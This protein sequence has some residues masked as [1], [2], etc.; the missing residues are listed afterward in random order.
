[1]NHT[2][3]GYILLIE[4]DPWLAE[5]Y[6]SLLAD[7]PKV[8]IVNSPQEAMNACDES[9]PKLIIADV[10]L[11]EGLV[12]DFLN[13]LQSHA[14]LASVPVILC[15]TIAS[16]FDEKDMRAYGVV[17]ILDKATLKPPML[18]SIVREYA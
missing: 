5:S 13:E 11:E 9:V 1:M 10:M 6:A 12:I 3:A 8:E 18:Q 14:D 15:S 16:R 4:D 2:H 17:K 7:G